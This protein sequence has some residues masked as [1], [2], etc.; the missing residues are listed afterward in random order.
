MDTETENRIRKAQEGN[1]KLSTKEKAEISKKYCGAV[2]V[3]EHFADYTE[4]ALDLLINSGVKTNIHF[5]V[6]SKTI[7]IAIDY[8]KNNSDATTSEIIKFETEEIFG[9]KPIS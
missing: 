7:D 6:S 5:V 3:S 2:A 9:I 8:L 4:K 1:K